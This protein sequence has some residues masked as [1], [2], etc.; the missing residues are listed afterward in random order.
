MLLD[1]D[2]EHE[3]QTHARNPENC[4]ADNT[5][6]ARATAALAKDSAKAKSSTRKT[7]EGLPVHS[8]R[9]LLDDLAT[10]TLNE[11]TLPGNPEDAFPM[12][13]QPTPLQA[14]AFEL[15]EIDPGKFVA[16]TRAGTDG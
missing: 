16:S 1:P 2:F 10:V 3:P 5:P 15:L 7:P 4:T 8:F 9:T 11:V 12:I 14:K 13:S 6:G